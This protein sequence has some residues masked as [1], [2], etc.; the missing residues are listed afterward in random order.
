MYHCLLQWKFAPP[1]SP[2][3]PLP[4][5]HPRHL[6]KPPPPPPPSSSFQW[7]LLLQLGQDVV[8][9]TEDIAIFA[10]RAID[11]DP[12]GA[13]PVGTI[14]CHLLLSFWSPVEHSL[15]EAGRAAAGQGGQGCGTQEVQS[16][17]DG[18]TFHPGGGK[19]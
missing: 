7:S 4:L 16:N 14:V 9:P 10:A 3:L 15:R 11:A 18:T 5:H 8:K 17:L 12:V 1:L 19:K 6:W 2:W 13:I